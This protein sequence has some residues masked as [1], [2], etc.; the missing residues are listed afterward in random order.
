MRDPYFEFD[1]SPW[2]PVLLALGI[3]ALGFTIFFFTWGCYNPD[4]PSTGTVEL[5]VV[6]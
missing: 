5:E 6:E 1:M 4:T 3:L 2:K